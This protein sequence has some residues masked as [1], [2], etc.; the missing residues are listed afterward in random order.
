[1]PKKTQ[2]KLQEK[3]EKQQLQPEMSTVQVT[4]FKT[5]REEWGGEST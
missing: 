1:M 4:Q 2:S 5:Q 3:T